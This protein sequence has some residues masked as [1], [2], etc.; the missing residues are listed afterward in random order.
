[1]DVLRFETPKEFLDATKSFRRNDPVRTGLI[2]SIATSVANGSRIYEGYFWWAVVVGGEV[3]G[4][5]MRTLPYGYIFSPMANSAAEALYTFISLED[6][7]AIEFA[8]PKSVIDSLEKV[9]AKPVSEEE[10]ELI[11][12][13]RKLIPA[14]PIG[15]V[16]TAVASDF[17]LIFKWM[18]EF[19]EE[20]ALRNFNLEN[21]V[22]V[23]LEAGRYTLLEVGSSVVSLGGTSDIQEFEGFSIGR[24]GPIYTPHEYRKRGY[25]SAITSAISE[26]LLNQGVVPNLYTQAGNPTSNK[27]Y[28]KLGYTLVEENRRIV[29]I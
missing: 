14:A 3:Q 16:R 15:V 4:I 27:I 22:H 12:E 2:T 7:K 10:S 26:K 5:A 8:G 6:S 19:I 13:M 24:V 23:A 25:A 29:L 11:Y 17:D 9:S 21:L 28:Q 18:Q 20:T 1:M